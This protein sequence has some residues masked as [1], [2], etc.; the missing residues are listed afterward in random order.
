MTETSIYD[1]RALKYAAAAK[2]LEC[3]EPGMKLGLGSGS[4]SAA[5]VDLLGVRVRDGLKVV[6]TSTSVVIEH[7]ARNLGI[8]LMPLVDLAPLDLVV[9]GA[10]EAD[11]DLNL[12]KGGGGA[13]TREKIVESSA[14][15]F[16]VIADGGKLVERL[17]KF[18]LPVEVVTFGHETTAARIAAAAAGLGYESL[19][20]TLRQADGKPF[21]TDN[22]N[23]IYDCRFDAISDVPALATALSGIP[24]VVEHGLFVGM[25][26]RLILARPEGV[27]VIPR[28]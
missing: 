17:G 24:G 11:A 27:E 21:V 16:I 3:V 26:E 7:K 15:R 23:V 9:D 19:A 8:E 2:A 12:I 20:M 10:D 6:C 14:K 28:R 25:A 1:V 13:L 5:F 22:G 18:P 4:T